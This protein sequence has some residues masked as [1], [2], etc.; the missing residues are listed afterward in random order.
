MH[1]ALLLLTLFAQ[2][3]PPLTTTVTGEG[4]PLLLLPGLGTTSEVFA[5]LVPALPGIQCVR[6]EVPGVGEGSLIPP[7]TWEQLNQAAVETMA[8]LGHQRFAVL[9]LSWGSFWAQKLALAHPDKIDHLILVG[10][11]AGGKT[12]VAPAPEVLQALLFPAEQ[13]LES[14][15]R[16]IAFAFH[17]DW[18]AA[19]PD[20]LHAMAQARLDHPFPPASRSAQLTLAFGFD[21]TA[22]A[23]KLQGPTLIL[24]GAEDRVVPPANGEHLAQL[25]VGAKLVKIP[26]SGHICVID[27]A[28]QCAEA[29][30]AFL[31]SP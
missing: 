16:V 3:T 24:H 27:Q 30:L 23:T 12:H 21:T 19:H 31:N 18:L 28:P 20:R 26:E 8:R 11:S 4:R 9:G 22:D 6:V 25:I 7:F 14:Q 15:E 17:P 10:G 1:L 5:D 2:D 13:T 29:I